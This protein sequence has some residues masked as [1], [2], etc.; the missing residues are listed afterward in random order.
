MNPANH[1]GQKLRHCVFS[2]LA[3][4]VLVSLPVRAVQAEG[5]STVVNSGNEIVVNGQSHILYGIKS[6]K[7]GDT[8][9]L[10]GKERDCG[11]LSRAGLMDLTAGAQVKCTAAPAGLIGSKCLSDGYDLSEGMVHTGWAEALGNAP[12]RLRTIMK[13]ARTKK[14]GLWHD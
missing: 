4:A 5:A 10:R 11:V 13:T 3:V 12:Q 8:C 6:P 9:Q 14:R 7:P 2:S 1:P